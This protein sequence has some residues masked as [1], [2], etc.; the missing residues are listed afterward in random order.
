MGLQLPLI[1]CNV[2]PEPTAYHADDLAKTTV[3]FA[4]NLS[5][6]C[7][8][9][10]SGDVAGDETSAKKVFD[11]FL[12]KVQ[13]VEFHVWKVDV[14]AQRNI[15]FTH[16]P[17]KLAKQVSETALGTYTDLLGWLQGQAPKDPK[18]RYW[19]TGGS[20][21]PGDPVAI[22]VKSAGASH[23]LRA[24]Q[25]YNA[26]IA[27]KFRLTHI[28]RLGIGIQGVAPARHHPLRPAAP[29]P[30]TQYLVLPYFGTSIAPLSPPTTHDVYDAP[31]VW[32]LEYDALG[33][34]GR[35]HCR[36]GLL[37]KDMP[38][39]PLDP[40]KIDDAFSSEGY[41]LVDPNAE[42]LRRVTRWFEDRAA[43][44][45][46]A[47]SALALQVAVDE[48]KDPYS[49]IF[50]TSTKG[51]PSSGAAWYATAALCSALD[52]L[53]IGILKPVSGL[54]SEGEILS[55][56]VSVLLETITNAVTGKF[57]LDDNAFQA[58]TVTA[59][60]RAAIT[61]T[62]LGQ[63]NRNRKALVDELRYVYDIKSTPDSTVGAKLL[64]ALLDYYV[65]Q[66]WTEPTDK[67][68]QAAVAN[69]GPTLLA[70]MVAEFVQKLHDQTG[71]EAAIVRLL[72]TG[73]NKLS[74]RVAA[75]YLLQIGQSGD[76]QMLAV[77]TSAVDAA[78]SSY[79][80][81]LTGPFNGAEAV[82][83]AAGSEFTKA[84]LSAIK[85]PPTQPSPQQFCELIEKSQFYS[86]RFLH[87]GKTGGC[88]DSIVL[89]LPIPSPPDSQSVR[90]HLN[91][92]FAAAMKPLAQSLEIATGFIPDST[93]QPLPIQIAGNIDGAH[94]DEFGK[95]FNGFG[96]GL[97]RIDTGDD[98]QDLWSHANL[99]ELS[100][101]TADPPQDSSKIVQAAIHPML[102]AVSD[103][104]GPMFIEYQGFPFADS[105]FAAT[106]LQQDRDAS[107]ASYKPFY[108]H[109]TADYAGSGF[110]RLPALAYGRTFESFGFLISNG[111]SLPLNSQG[112]WPWMPLKQLKDPQGP[113]DKLVAQADYQ[114]RTAIGQMVHEETK[115]KA[116]S[117]PNW[118]STTTRRIGAPIPDVLPLSS[119]YPRI[120]LLAEAATD[121]VRD[122]FREMNGTGS[123][124]IGSLSGDST[125]R[126][127]QQL[128][129]VRWVGAPQHLTLGLFD[130]PASGPDDRGKDFPFALPAA[131]ADLARITTIGIQIKTTRTAGGENAT[132]D[133]DAWVTCG[134]Q[135]LQ[136]QF[137]TTSGTLWIRLWLETGAQ[138]ASMSFA[139]PSSHKADSVDAPLLLLAAPESQSW[140]DGIATGV[141][142]A[143]HTPC[144]GYLDFERWFFNDDLLRLA[145]KIDAHPENRITADRLH[146]FLLLSYVMR[147]QN[148]DL[149][150]AL[151][152]LPDPAVD[153][154]RI[155]LT[156][157]DQLIEKTFIGLS[158][159]VD[160]SGWLLD[161]AGTLPD[162][163]KPPADYS[164]QP[165]DQR[166]WKVDQLLGVVFKP[167]QQKFQFGIEIEAAAG[168]P[169]LG[170][171]N[172]L[173]KATLPGGLTARLSTDAL[174]SEQH[175]AGKNYHPAVF[176]HGLLQ[177]VS[178]HVE[179]DYLAFPSHGI[180]LETML[181]AMAAL[182]PPGAIKLAADMIEVVPNDRSRRYD[183]VTKPGL[184]DSTDA[185]RTRQWRLL[186]Q[187]DVA[188]QRWRPTGKPIYHYID[189]KAFR[190]DPKAP[191]G[192]GG[193][194]SVIFPALRIYLDG[195]H[196]ALTNF[197]AEAFFARLDIDAQTITQTLQPLPSRTVLQ[198]H[199]WD[200]PSATYFRHR[201]T[202]R[203]RYAGA[204]KKIGDQQVPAWTS[205]TWTMRVAMLADLSRILLTRPQLR[206]LIPLT[207]SPDAGE[208]R[209]PPA[210]PVAAILQEPPFA[211]GG[212]ADRIAAEVK[213]GFGYGFEKIVDP[214]NPP[215]VEILDSRKEIGP[216]PFLDYRPLD[217]SA[218]LGTALMVEGPMGLTFDPTGASA[219]AFPNSMM[220]LSPVA[221]AG[222]DPAMEEYFV[223]VSMR[224]YID[225]AWT[226]ENEAVPD[227]ILAERCW[228]IEYSDL[229][230]KHDLLA[231]KTAT[232][233]QTLLMIEEENG[234]FLIKTKKAAIDG[235][236]GAKEQD[237]TLAR[238]RTD[239]AHPL[240][241]LH[242]PMA[243]GR[244]STSV[245]ALPTLDWTATARGRSN[246]PLLLANF[247]WS[248]PKDGNDRPAAVELVIG[249]VGNDV[250]VTVLPTIASAPTAIAW[251]KTN[252]DFD[253]VHTAGFDEKTAKFEDDTV[254]VT[255]LIARLTSDQ[256]LTFDRSN[257]YA[258]VWLC[259]ST[260]L[261]KY[262]IHLHRHLALLTTHYMEGPGRPLESIS[263]SAVLT[264]STAGLVPSGS[265]I[266]N[267]VR[268]IEF[269]TP[270]SILCGTGTVPIPG[271]YKTA[272]F[273]LVSTGFKSNADGALRFFFRFAG[274]PI[275]LR[276]FTKLTVTVWI[277]DASVKKPTPLDWHVDLTKA[278]K[279]LF[280]LGVELL[281]GA[282]KT[283][284]SLLLSDGS[285]SPPQSLT[286][287]AVDKVDNTKPGLI[288]SIAAEG[289]TAEFWA[290]V[291]LLHSSAAAGSFDFGWLFSQP[292]GPDGAAEVKPQALTRMVEAQAR[293]VS[294]SPPIPIAL[295]N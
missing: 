295:K 74:A 117:N 158:T 173:V 212:L 76:P 85:F 91:A 58:R 234:T 224:R 163:S 227:K 42:D 239:F 267:R 171:Q 118:G 231:Y 138:P 175:F 123:L 183:I 185:V 248:P 184:P 25:S 153:K 100:W 287:L 162:P 201:F 48:T 75:S 181:D 135:T 226:L 57:K 12:K 196:G 253:F 143:V 261:N 189:P 90:D 18:T 53:L 284:A 283:T 204:L 94:L 4:V 93:P 137:T 47:S 33:D 264:G 86:A 131:A 168:D 87:L 98:S 45:M 141:T 31:F 108:R 101:D 174:V 20:G 14:D 206:A 39:Q 194:P 161:F 80:Q 190:N 214:A 41:L 166:T 222:D 243:P 233:Q 51:V 64:S 113:I 61:A 203:S 230:G 241:V 82:R 139:D 23:R 92:A 114:R 120:G 124:L 35:V 89:S 126:V 71:V 292:G 22:D 273:D 121:G 218:A 81:L 216:S 211:R 99:A 73:S 43:S 19:S 215:P 238:L 200:S 160:L 262:P 56:L 148:E 17:G 44:L 270:A 111:G 276:K 178:R 11:S 251:T 142:V 157:V 136:R 151:D 288:I 197:E 107:A 217:E 240:V 130:G 38:L 67:A 21:K 274:S 281:V 66:S 165:L 169:S 252:R 155:E 187:I 277:L 177:Y 229:S 109:Y 268:I 129:D 176:H 247:E 170:S 150:A 13:S 50:R 29:G 10:G 7:P 279:G 6:E 164:G 144:V 193:N 72:E 290:D 106:M 260:L 154:V 95:H 208:A 256:K 102:P 223:G 115:T 182:T 258:P 37:G 16:D 259:S 293:I 213:T 219:P 104:R 132:W 24:A 34:M 291:S 28:V 59:A 289:T 70:S 172:G 60:L 209:K 221:V 96:V 149:A 140:L 15:T 1:Y 255:E 242:Q 68:A 5:L 127:E 125:I 285:M 83:R 245:L 202:L 278:P 8:S 249:D 220:T 235:V 199:V 65:N 63:N 207:T 77:V 146:Q 110:I 133:V 225:P 265:P 191:R 97:R 198:Q 188:T 134:G 286:E 55:P 46:S 195:D 180:R 40:A 103:G 179:G 147:H 282:T 244:Y 84:A 116:T 122:I 27:H 159:S 52:P 112:D 205:N 69:L 119:D 3:S 9:D 49:R 26:P 280:T 269:E 152:R 272:Y 79:R 266:D 254:G 167:L 257:E 156:F 105:T 263:R 78:W 237:V 88:F 30:H 271:T 62:P 54:D 32:D 210:P 145:F 246:S 192:G 250:E 236:Q 275:H 228:W 36:T 294:V 2:D 128:A 232:T 186:G